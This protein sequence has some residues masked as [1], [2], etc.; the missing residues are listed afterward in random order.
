MEIDRQS[1]EQNRF[2]L[3]KTNQF[4]SEII[5]ESDYSFIYEKI[6]EN[7]K[8]LFIDEFQDTSALQWE[9]LKPILK[10]VLAENNFGMLVGD[11][12]QSIYRWRNGDWRILN[13]IENEFGE[14]VNYKKLDKNWRSARNI[15]QFNNDLFKNISQNF[16]DDIKKAY[17]D[18]EQI[19]QKNTDGLVSVDFVAHGKSW[20]TYETE[21][22]ENLMINAIA[23]KVKILLENGD[24][25]SDICILC[26]N[27]KQIRMI[28]EKLP[29]LLPQV[30]IISEQA[31]VFSNSIELKMIIC[32]LRIIENPRNLV[33]AAAL[34]KLQGAKICEITR[35]KCEEEIIAKICELSGFSLK[36]TVEKL[37]EKF[38]FYEKAISPFLSAF[39]DILLDFSAKKKSDINSFLEYWDE[40]LKDE[41]LPL[42]ANKNDKRDGIMALTIHKSKGL[43]FHS[44][45]VAFADWAMS[46]HSS[47]FKQ[48]LLWCSGKNEPFDIAM[49]PVEYSQILSKSEFYYDYEIETEAQNMDNLN[50]LYVALTRAQKNLF[51][52]AK[53]QDKCIGKLIFDFSETIGETK[54]E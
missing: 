9:N 16:C 22:G 4:L 36:E 50:V 33:S 32:A 31:Y 23:E 54:S 19:P 49:I 18:A 48:N 30:K 41:T 5:G 40:K 12:K 21:D 46:E 2:M 27:G 7:I 37:Y 10:D 43:Q 15:V 6:G 44:V 24:A 8:N 29:K 28:A 45:I 34:L 13:D 51:V 42:P 1:K 52:L 11:V 25:Q 39:M 20:N 3:A 14:N 53:K 26:R 47:P 38:G 17:N 35:E